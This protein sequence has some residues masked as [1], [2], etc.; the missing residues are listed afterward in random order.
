METK[1]DLKKTNNKDKENS[2]NTTDMN[3]LLGKSDVTLI[4][5]CI[6]FKRA[7]KYHSERADRAGGF[8]LT[9]ESNE[10]LAKSFEFEG[11]EGQI[12]VELILRKSIAAIKN[13]IF[14]NDPHIETICDPT[15]R[16]P[17]NDKEI[18]ELNKWF[19]NAKKNLSREE[20]EIFNFDMT[21][22][23]P[24][25]KHG[26]ADHF[27]GYIFDGFD[28]KTQ[29]F[30]DPVEWYSKY[31]ASH[32]MGGE[33]LFAEP[34]SFDKFKINPEN[35]QKDMLAASKING[36]ISDDW[37]NFENKNGRKASFDEVVKI[38]KAHKPFFG[39][40]KK[41]FT[42]LQKHENPQIA[43]AAT[44]KLKELNRLKIGEAKGRKM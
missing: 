8:G 15:L 41:F 6:T 10:Q 39:D 43:L 42:Q 40:P 37:R 35:Y 1:H 27:T 13:R 33:N 3:T 30:I 14:D 22:K 36:K 31:A 5:K 21:G 44:F 17:T 29:C 11:M 34:E 28:E 32:Y 4:T 20:V 2:L 18:I 38:I 7:A 24:K 26:V 16:L 23:S 25:E 19:K 9:Y 12:K